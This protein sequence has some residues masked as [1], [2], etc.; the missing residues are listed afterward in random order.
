MSGLHLKKS[1]MCRKTSILRH[2]LSPG[3]LQKIG[4]QPVN[5]ACL[6]FV[7]MLSAAAADLQGTNTPSVSLLAEFRPI[8]GSGNNRRNPRLN[9]IPG[10]AELAL[11][12]LNFAP[13][14]NDGLVNG[15]NAR[16]ISNVIAGGTGANG[17]NGQTTDPLASAWL[18]VFGQFVDHD[19]DLEETPLTSAPI[20]ILVPPGDPVF[21]QGT[22]IAMTRDTRNPF[23]N[24]IVNTVAGYLDLSQLYGSTTAIAASLR[25]PDGTLA[26][27]DNGLAL[28]VVNDTFI[29]GDPRV[30]ENPELTALTILF[31]REHN[32]WVQAL[33][34]QHPQWTGDQLYNMAKAITT[35]EYQNI[36]YT[37][38]LP[39]LI[40]PVLGPY[41]GYNPNV[42]AQ[43]TQEFSTAAFRMGHSEVSDTQE[44][45]DNNENVVFTE[46]LAQSFFNTPEIDESN[47]I[48]PLLRSL[49]VDFA[50]ATDIYTVS[51]LRN[52]LVAGLVGG[53]VDEIDL[54]A[55]DI[56]RERDVG[57]GTL[58]QTRQALGF[59]RYGSFAELTSDPVLQQSLQAVYGNI[60]N[61]DLFMGGLA[62][63]HAP[64]ADVGPTFQAIIGRQFQA[65][66]TG[67]RFFWQN[68]G[69][70][71]QTASMIST[72]TLTD[73]MKRNTATPRL[74]ANLFVQSSLP[75]HVKP[76]ATTPAVIDTHGRKVSPFVNDG[77]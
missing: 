23:T 3:L 76:H 6:L 11:T 34:A 7:G 75:T 72:T 56:Q 20:N 71:R 31:M 54:I 58:N 52:L 74:Q 53:G 64:G 17:Q 12:P 36:V 45:I 26:S 4:S 44:G 25:N 73:I 55:I 29:T 40:G 59:R 18:Y 19:I 14:T 47:G 67:D 5:I 50:Q 33:K 28:P 69:F 60:N 24:T 16:V 63:R 66:R 39:I 22:S 21:P 65:L 1:F 42:N 38:Y 43:V 77:M 51:A 68:Q 37:E 13:G 48:D 15:P 57:L 32:F 46:S 49:G 70:D 9:A 41:S 62:E 30:M 61:L 2:G 27:S 10:S 35:A 8:G